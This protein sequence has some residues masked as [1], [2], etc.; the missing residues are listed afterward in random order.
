MSYSIP[1]ICLL[2]RGRSTIAPGP[3]W[4]PKIGL[5]ANVVLLCWTLFTLVMYSFPFIMPAAAGN[6]NYVSV[7]YAVVATIVATDWLA[8]GRKSFR[9][10]VERIGAAEVALETAVR[11]DSVG[12]DGD[13]RT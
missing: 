11:R 10:K 1:V 5:F 9:S 12:R 7:V 3:F 6:M 4:F 2:F 8:R 13:Q